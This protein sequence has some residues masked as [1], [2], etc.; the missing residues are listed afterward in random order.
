MPQFPKGAVHLTEFLHEYGVP[1][2]C[3]WA[4]T[5]AT[6]LNT[7]TERGAEIALVAALRHHNTCRAHRILT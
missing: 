7:C 4:C 6:F 5:E 2:A 1:A 3:L